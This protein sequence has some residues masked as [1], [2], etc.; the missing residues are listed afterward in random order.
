MRNAKPHKLLLPT[1]VIFLMGCMTIPNVSRIQEQ[2]RLM[3]QL[4]KEPDLPTWYTQR[5]QDSLA[6]GDRVYDKDFSRVFDSLT[7]ALANLGMQVT[8]MERQ[9]GYIAANGNLLPPERYASL[10]HEGLVE[11]CRYYGY[12]PSLLE[13]KKGEID[14]DLSAGMRSPAVTISLVR[15]GDNQTKV[16]VRFTSIY[17]PPILVEHYR[18]IWLA[19]DKQIFLDKN[20]D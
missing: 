17:Y 14:P 15:Q 11:Y 6:I 10:R 1:I 18:S 12:S 5:E 7:I 13:V 16:K 2:S 20:L 9:S 8:N 19:L 4:M 3:Q